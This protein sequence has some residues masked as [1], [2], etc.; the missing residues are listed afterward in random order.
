MV[1]HFSGRGIGAPTLPP[2]QAFV[3]RTC[4]VSRRPSPL[5]PAVPTMPACAAMSVQEVAQRFCRPS[6]VCEKRDIDKLHR[7][8]EVLRFALRERA[9]RFVRENARKTLVLQYGADVTPL[10]TVE[11]HTASHAGLSVVREGRE[12][13]EFLVQRV[14]LEVEPGKPMALLEVPIPMADKTAY[15]HFAAGRALLKTPR[16]LGHEGLCISFHKYDRALQTA[17]DRMHR[18]FQAAW[19]DKQAEGDNE[20]RSYRLWLTNWFFC[21]GCFAHDCHGGLKW[22]VMGLTTGSK[23]AMRSI[24]ILH[25]SLRHGYGLLVKHVGAWLQVV[26]AFEDW[27][28]SGAR[29]VYQLLDVDDEW[30]PSY[31][32]LQ[33]RFDGKRLLVAKKFAEHDDLVGLLTTVL[34]KTWRFRKF[35]ESRP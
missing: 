20:G 18:Q 24:F 28:N 6:V 12:S 29:E 30:L 2:S 31:V 26:L 9:H 34:L 27:D 4:G 35:T 7:A 14:F 1:A 23:D 8:C 16:E 5:A 25:E 21:V 19:D 17:L 22:A 11:R 10:L 13:N 3:R 32:D 33:I 15:T